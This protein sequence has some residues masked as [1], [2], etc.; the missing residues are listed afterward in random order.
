MSSRT[1]VYLTQLQRRRV[2]RVLVVGFQ[3]GEQRTDPGAFAHVD[4]E[5]VLAELGGELVLVE[6]D[7]VDRLRRAPVRVC[8]S[9]VRYFN[10]L[11]NTL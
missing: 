10:A 4:G 3:L 11:F 6:D 5:D 9:A 2:D 8:A 1:P 7:Y